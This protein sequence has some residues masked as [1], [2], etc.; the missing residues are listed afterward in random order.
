MSN[1]FT[2]EELNLFDEFITAFDYDMTISNL[3]DKHTLGDQD[4]YRTNDI[5]WLSQPMI[6]SSNTGLDQTGNFG[7]VVGLSVPCSINTHKSVPKSWSA[8][9]M[10]DPNNVQ[11][12]FNAAKTRLATDITTACLATAALK[13]SIVKKKTTAVSGYSDIGDM[14]VLF[15]LYGVP[16]SDRIAMLAGADYTA[17][18]GTLVNNNFGGNTQQMNALERSAIGMQANFNMYRQNVPYNITA[19]TAA[20]VTVSGANQRHNP[21]PYLVDSAT[22][23]TSNVDNTKMNLTIAVGSGAMAVGDAF[24]INNVFHVHPIT[25]QV[26]SELKTFRVLAVNSSTSITISPAIIAADSSPTTAQTMYQNV[27]ATPAN[28]AAITLLNT[29]T[30]PANVFFHK[31]AMNIVPGGYV[32]EGDAGWNVQKATTDNGFQIT[33]AKQADINTG[34]IKT[35]VDVGFGVNVLNPEMMGIELFNQT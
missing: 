19:K 33:Y 22:G 14:E 4:A 25:K 13:G 35:R 3:I 5:F 1:A 6:V 12:M 8:S 10:R 23:G 11:K 34:N 2:K 16:T 15:D 31:E 28:G 24:T 27:S 9:D 7:D 18:V 21:V 20:T 17:Y 29:V 26:T 32:F 30:K